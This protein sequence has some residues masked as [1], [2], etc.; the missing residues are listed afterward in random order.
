[1]SFVPQRLLLAASVVLWGAAAQ[2]GLF[3]KLMKQAPQELQS[4]YFLLARMEP[5]R[6]HEVFKNPPPFATILSNRVV[7]A[8]GA[9]RIIEG[10]I[11][12][13]QKGT[14]VYMVSFEGEA[15]WAVVQCDPFKLVVLER[16]EKGRKRPTGLVLSR[17][18]T[19]EAQT[20]A[21]PAKPQDAQAAGGARRRRQ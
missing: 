21:P 2:A 20:N 3:P 14:N 8:D 16:N 18:P 9:V 4:E 13:R 1:M 12:V 6:P 19:V 11:R 10:V 7:L 17:K 5:D 15:S